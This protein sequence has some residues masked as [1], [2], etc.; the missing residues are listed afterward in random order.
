L[1][2]LNARNILGGHLAVA[3]RTIH[4]SSRE[5]LRDDSATLRGKTFLLKREV[6]A[7]GFR[8]VNRLCRYILNFGRNVKTKFAFF[9]ETE[10]GRAMKAQKTATKT[11]MYF[12]QKRKRRINKTATCNSKSATSSVSVVANF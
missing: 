10:K 5:T 12:Q 3:G 1:S 9:A 11:Q 7:T 8:T 2:V 4:V 6:A